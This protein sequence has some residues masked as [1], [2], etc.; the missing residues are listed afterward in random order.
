MIENQNILTMTWF[1]VIVSTTPFLIM[2]TCNS[3]LIKERAILPSIPFPFLFAMKSNNILD[4][5]IVKLLLQFTPINQIFLTH[6][7]Q[8]QTQKKHG[9][10]LKCTI[11]I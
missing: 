3:L 2:L 7:Y 11:F 1:Q 6:L 5:F 4:N 10:T 9:Q 8:K